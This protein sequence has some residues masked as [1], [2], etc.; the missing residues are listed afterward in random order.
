MVVFGRRTPP[1]SIVTRNRA[2]GILIRMSRFHRYCALLIASTCLATATAFGRTGTEYNHAVKATTLFRTTTD[3]A[4]TPLA[5]PTSGQAEVSGLIVELPTG[6]E[7]GWHRH[8]VP[9][10]AYIIEGEIEVTQKDGPTRTFKA[11]D[12]FAEMVGIEHNGR[13]VGDRPVRLVFFA[14]G[15]EG[16]AFTTK[17]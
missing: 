12:A 7:T 11:G 5:Y 2:C 15:V 14:A 1:D 3:V 8:S 6:A 16:E 4:G 9:C 10:F 17:D 13:T